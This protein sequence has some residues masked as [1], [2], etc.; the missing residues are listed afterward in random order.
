M[1]PARIGWFRHLMHGDSR[2]VNKSKAPHAIPPRQKLITPWNSFVLLFRT[3]PPRYIRP[4]KGRA[5]AG[6]LTQGIKTT[7]RVLCFCTLVDCVCTKDM[8]GE[9][10]KPVITANNS[11]ITGGVYV[12]DWVCVCVPLILPPQST[13]CLVSHL[14]SDQGHRQ[15]LSTEYPFI[16]SI[17]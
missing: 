6:R 4:L 5:T 12:C 16:F 3:E 10:E 1:Y 15:T 7:Y 14:A 13:F 9:G 11:Q 2:G 17:P 8:S